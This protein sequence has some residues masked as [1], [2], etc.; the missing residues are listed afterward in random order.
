MKLTNTYTVTGTPG[1]GVIFQRVL[2]IIIIII[3]V[4]AATA[5]VVIVFTPRGPPPG[6]HRGEGKRA[7]LVETSS[8]L[9]AAGLLGQ[10][11]NH[12]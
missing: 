1:I 8:W 5:I 12:E 10:P 2:A 9:G 3:T 7:V 11:Q 4:D 6:E